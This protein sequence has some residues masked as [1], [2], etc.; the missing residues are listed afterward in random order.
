MGFGNTEIVG[1]L[2]EAVADNDEFAFTDEFNQFVVTEK[3][4]IEFTRRSFEPVVV[5]N[6]EAE[7]DPID[8]NFDITTLTPYSF[9]KICNSRYVFKDGYL[10]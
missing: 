7:V 4:K 3:N 6:F 8:E 1:E 2:D 10:Y 5:H 9:F